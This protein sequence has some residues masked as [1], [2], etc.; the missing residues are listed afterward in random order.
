MKYKLKK[1]KDQIYLVDCENHYDLCMLFLRYQEF[2]ESPNSKFR[3]KDFQILDYMEWWSKTKGNG[4]FTYPIAWGGF[5]IPSWVIH[6]FHDLQSNPHYKD[7]NKY[8]GEMFRI[9]EK[10]K[11]KNINGLMVEKETKPFYLIGVSK[12][13][14]EALDHELAHGLYY[15]NTE[16]RL[17]MNKLVKALPSSLKKNINAWLKEAGYTSQVFKDETQAYLAT[18]FP[19]NIK[20][21]YKKHQK[22][23]QEVFKKFK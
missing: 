23:F 7:Y 12:S 17:A 1:I 5:N 9:Y 22:Q 16:Y 11:F 10:I 4:S 18:G 8:D 3:G 19:V 13:S 2:Y 6:H 21:S 15:T 14:S 20:I